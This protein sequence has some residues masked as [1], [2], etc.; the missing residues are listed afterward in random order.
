VLFFLAFLPLDAGRVAARA[1]TSQALGAA[2]GLAATF[3]GADDVARAAENLITRYQAQL[4]E[5]AAWCDQHGLAREAQTT[6]DWFKPRDPT[7]LYVAMSPQTVGAAPLPADAPPDAIQWHQRF[8]ALRQEQADAL[9]GLARS[10]VRKGR[11]SLAFDLVMLALHENPDHE[12]IRKLLGYQKYQGQWRTLYEV[13]RLSAGQVWDDQF[14][15][16]P[17]AFVERYH[18]GWRNYQGRWITTEE[19]ARIHSDIRSGW[20]I[21]TEH[22]TIRTNHSLEAGVDLGVRL[23]RLYRV[24]KRLFIRYYA[25]E[26]QVASLFE[27][28]GRRVESGPRHGVVYFRNKEQYVQALQASYPNIGISLGIYIDQVQLAGLSGL[29]LQLRPGQVQLGR[30]YF[31]ADDQGDERTLIHEA[32]HQLFHESRAVPPGVGTRSNFWIMEGIAMY[33]ES[34]RDEDGYHVLG[35]FDDLRM[36]AARYRLLNDHFYV[37]LAEFTSWG[38]E[39]IQ[40]DPRIATL[41]SQAAGLTSFLVHY[42]GG[43]YRDALVGYLAAVYS[44][45]DD[46]LTLVRLTGTPYPELDR[47]YREYIECEGKK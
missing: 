16:L 35:G 34:L 24:W 11:S 13:N 39:K 15:W 17:K 41:Y 22:Y 43:R 10:A 47:Q 26:G 20:D 45:R 2:G 40:S 42:E 1:A 27:G 23:E 9:F 46:P 12:P 28:A 3:S 19:D 33:M 30:A 18:S 44:G 14:G 36:K 32:T 6:R 37:P 4:G 7:K 21:Q 31:F 38:M 8:L 25:T 29:G 5:L